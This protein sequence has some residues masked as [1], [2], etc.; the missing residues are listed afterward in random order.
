[1]IDDALNLFNLHFFLSI[2]MKENTNI[3]YCI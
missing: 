3:A 1:M 2:Y